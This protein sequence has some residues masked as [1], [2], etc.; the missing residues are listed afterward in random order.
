MIV[1]VQQ[2]Y[3]CG[4]NGPKEARGDVCPS[5][6]D[7]KDTGSGQGPTGVDSR[8]NLGYLVRDVAQQANNG[9]AR[10]NPL[11]Q[12]R[13]VGGHG[14]AHSIPAVSFSCPFPLF[15]LTCARKQQQV[16]FG[17]EDKNKVYKI[18]P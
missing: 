8:V 4:H 17:N 5:G 12:L 7:G 11:P 10:G 1:Y 16:I 6:D 14:E 9:L 2:V 18:H 13:L 15:F 3:Q